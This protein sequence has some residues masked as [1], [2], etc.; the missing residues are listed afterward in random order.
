MAIFKK[1]NVGA[2]PR[3]N[4]KTQSNPPIHLPKIPNPFIPKVPNPFIQTKQ[5]ETDKR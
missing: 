4:T 5:A 3:D 2:K 1:G